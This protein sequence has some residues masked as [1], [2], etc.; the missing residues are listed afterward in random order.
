MRFRNMVI[1]IC[2]NLM[3]GRNLSLYQNIL[4]HRLIM[5]FYHSDIA[6]SNDWKQLRNVVILLTDECNPTTVAQTVRFLHK[7]IEK[8]SDWRFTRKNRGKGFEPVTK[9]LMKN[10]FQTDTK[11]NNGCNESLEGLLVYYTAKNT[12][13]ALLTERGQN[14]SFVSKMRSWGHRISWQRSLG[15]SIRDW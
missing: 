6:I 2:R 14:C 9:I 1:S 12:S 8:R 13:P 15:Y 7:K 10:H 3:L 5:V 4:L 11:T